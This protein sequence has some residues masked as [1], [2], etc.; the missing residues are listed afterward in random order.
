MS[1]QST[2]PETLPRRAAAGKSGPSEHKQETDALEWDL[3]TEEQQKD[4]LA[5]LS[6]MPFQ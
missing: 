4:I 5:H 2:K 6:D 1:R 3:M